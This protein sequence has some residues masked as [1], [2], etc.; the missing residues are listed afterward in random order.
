M[1]LVWLQL[2]NTPAD[3]LDLLG[4]ALRY[5]WKEGISGLSVVVQD[6]TSVGPVPYTHPTL[7]TKLRGCNVWVAADVQADAARCCQ[8]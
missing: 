1:A 5:N 7:P 6:E 4:P 3:L 2:S 8:R